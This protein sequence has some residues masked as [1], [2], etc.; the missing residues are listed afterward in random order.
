[1]TTFRAPAT[2]SLT[3]AQWLGFLSLVL[4]NLMA[5]MDVSIVASS[6]LDIQA[7]LAASAENMAWVQSAYLI[8]EVIAIPMTGYL[9]RLLSTRT[10][11]LISAGGFTLMSVAAA[12][13]WNID[14]MIAFRFAQGLLGGAMIP[15]TMSVIFILFPKEQ[16]MKA[17][18]LVGLVSTMGPVIGPTL[19]GY[20]TEMLSWHWLFLVNIGPGILIVLGVSRFFDIDKPDW[21]L[22]RKIDFPGI[23]SMAGFLGALEYVLEE[24]PRNG[25]LDDS[26][27]ATV[28]V[29]SVIS[30]IVFFWRMLVAEEP[31]VDLR[32]LR[33]RNFALGSAFAFVLGVVLYGANFV[34]PLYLGQVRG[35]SSMQIGE[36]MAVSGIVM[37]LAAP[38]VGKASSA[39]PKRYVV[40]VGLACIAVGSFLASRMDSQWGFNEM[41]VPQLVRGFGL[42]CCFIPLSALALG[43]MPADQVKNASGLYNL[44]RNLGGAIGLAYL[45]TLVTSRQAFHWQQLIPNIRADRPEAVQAIEAATARFA[46][47]GSADPGAAAIASVAQNIRME[48]LVMTYNDLFGVICLLAVLAT[49]AVPLLKETNTS[50]DAGGH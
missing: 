36:L 12:F 20:L 22:L 8:A 3:L 44:M 1:M 24:G 39:L 6:L 33:N 42:V 34:M 30:A 25:W 31:L 17:Q 16:Q 23:I 7:G 21:S 38:L 9:S 14:S 19:G 26:A 32:C 27:I 18:V 35:Y 15:T 49:L 4:G 5:I 45:N 46:S 47:A 40:G 10:F 48:G 13:A 11:F 28:L 29:I 2:G 37:F 41:L 43:T 50:V